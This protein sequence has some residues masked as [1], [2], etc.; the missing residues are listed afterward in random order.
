M[1]IIIIPIIFLSASGAWWIFEYFFS[2]TLYNIIYSLSIKLLELAITLLG[3]VD[4]ETLREHNFSE[5][6]AGIPHQ[7]L[8]IFSSMGVPTAFKIV[9][10]AY[11]MRIT[12]R[13]LGAF[14]PVFRF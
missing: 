8:E 10:T 6:M 5:L 11:I 1:F 9:M 2:G 3:L 7:M 12:L 14:I 4:S 13:I